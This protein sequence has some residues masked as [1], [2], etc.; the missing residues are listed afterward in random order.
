M[1]H[2]REPLRRGLKQL[3]TIAHGRELRG[4]TPKVLE[5]YFG[6]I[7]PLYENYKA[8]EVTNIL[9][10]DH[11]LRVT[12]NQYKKKISDW[13]KAGRLHYKNIPKPDMQIMVHEQLR[14]ACAGE[15]VKF[16]YRTGPV[17]PEKLDRFRKKN[18]IRNSRSP[19]ADIPQYIECKTESTSG[20]ES[21]QPESCSTKSD[22]NDD[23][24]QAPDR[25]LNLESSEPAVAMKGFLAS[26]RNDAKNDSV[27]QDTIPADALSVDRE[28]PDQYS[29]WSEFMNDEYL[30]SLLTGQ[31]VN[32]STDSSELLLLKIPASRSTYIAREVAAVSHRL[33]RARKVGVDDL[34]FRKEVDTLRDEIK[35]LI[36]ALAREL[37]SQTEFKKVKE[38]LRI[39]AGQLKQTYKD[40]HFGEITSLI[41]LKQI[42]Q[43]MQ[44]E[45]KTWAFDLI[46]ICDSRHLE[47]QQETIRTGSHNGQDSVR[48]ETTYGNI[49]PVTIYYCC[50]C[51]HGPFTAKLFGA[52]VECQHEFC[53]SCTEEFDL[54]QPISGP[55]S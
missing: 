47:E 22:Q 8:T 21:S 55:S 43:Q 30:E 17:K 11:S 41:F 46:K 2:P 29:A 42:N 45:E 9:R 34:S 5:E 49:P 40:I 50:Y 27:Q 48:L 6:I 51:A 35:R 13:Q 3:A 4:A 12:L 7:E 38:L 25:P 44:E 10:R 26:W 52:C 54:E 28:A 16:R 1:V 39:L 18:R 15:K 14:K 37:G 32:N 24:N 36:P 23:S 53:G 20:D 31:T 19:S 33:Q